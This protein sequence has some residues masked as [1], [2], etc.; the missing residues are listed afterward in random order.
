MSDYKPAVGDRVRVVLEG[1][2][3]Y[4]PGGFYTTRHYF[5]QGDPEVVS[6]E[7]IEPPV[8]VF[9][10]GDVVRPK[11]KSCE[12]EYLLTSDGWVSF[13]GPWGALGHHYNN[14]MRTHTVIIMMSQ[15]SPGTAERNP[16]V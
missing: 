2:V 13:R 1:E 10:P 14:R 3:N 8:T 15:G 9:K 4:S 11:S 7:K 12:F 5:S 16:P 6:I